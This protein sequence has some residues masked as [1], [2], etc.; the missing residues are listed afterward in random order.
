MIYIDIDIYNIN[1]LPLCFLMK[2]YCVL[3]HDIFVFYFIMR[4]SKLKI[5][6]DVYGK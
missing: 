1:Q 4:T 5:A 2:V 6:A 3:N